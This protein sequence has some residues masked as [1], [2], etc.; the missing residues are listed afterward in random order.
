[1]EARGRI[2]RAP[3]F[4]LRLPA[5]TDIEMAFGETRLHLAPSPHDLDAFAGRNALLATRNGESASVV[6][7]W[8]GYHVARHGAGA[9]VIFDRARPGRDPAFATELTE[10]LAA[11]GLA[12]RVA[13]VG[14]DMALGRPDMPPEAHPACVPEAPGKERMSVPPPDP[15]SS[16]LGE[17]ALPEI[18]R[19][20]FLGRARAVANID[21]CDLLAP[22]AEVRVFDMAAGAPSGAIDLIGRHAF[23]WRL[24]KGRPAGFGD[25]V[26]VQFDQ[27]N[28]RRRWCLAPA[29]LPPGAVWRFARVGRVAPDPER[30]GVFYRF[31]ALRHPVTAVSRIV[32][33]S[34]LKEHPPLV[35]L[36]GSLGHLPARMPE[37]APVPA[38]GGGR[39]IVTTMKNEG[40]FILE[41]LAFH[42]AVGFD[43][44]LVYSNDCTDGTDDLLDLL[45]ER[46]LVQHRDNPFRATGQKPQHAALHTAEREPLVRG[47]EWIAAMDVDEFV[48]VKVG[49]GTLDD[50]FD[51]MPGA[52]MISMTW[53]LFGNADIDRFEDRFVTEQFTLCAP[54]HVR[55]PHHAWGFK[56]LY[57][58]LGLF[59]KLGVHRPK[60]LNPQLWEEIAWVNGS[61]RKLP[62]R[63]YRNA[64][65]S[66]AETY[67]YD[68]VALNHYA[69]RSAES[70]LVKRDRGRANHADRDQ[71]LGYW[72]RMNHNVEEDR[73]IAARIPAARAE[74][75]RLMADPGI[76]RLHAH[77]VARHRA[78]IAE[79]KARPD[80]AAF[81]AALTGPRLRKLSRMLPNF[82]S[83]VFLAGPDAIPDEILDRDPSER[84][85]FTV[86]RR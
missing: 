75:A 77:C 19:A 50:L 81:H 41:W 80:Q 9:A 16:P 34:S 32:P 76:A 72:F 35:A 67:G 8:L 44:F 63:M 25:H 15:W 61:G 1:M 24:R 21:V 7:D 45:Q 65:R 13:L 6:L 55:K 31:M 17:P 70:F 38:E 11:S 26:C 36:A 79:L 57:R 49:K 62:R 18:A 37:L 47:A 58:N 78:R 27:P 86:P 39:V 2:G 74:Y 59:R 83:N 28:L 33:K 4:R 20:R 56:T 85:A 14:A 73:S 66:T 5:G 3:W 68:L 42:R 71:G 12:V 40:P 43:G 22:E 29:R 82:G 84:F 52:N 30:Q 23:P 10:G 48:N 46:G 53:R 69:V 60:G 51:A 64:W 54:E